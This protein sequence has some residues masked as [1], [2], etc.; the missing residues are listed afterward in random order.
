MLSWDSNLNAL[1]IKCNTNCDQYKTMHQYFS[2]IFFVNVAGQSMYISPHGL[3][4]QDFPI[5]K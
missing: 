3:H 5:G 1:D 2:M 4:K